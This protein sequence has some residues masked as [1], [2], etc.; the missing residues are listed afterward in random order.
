MK[1]FELILYAPNT[2]IPCKWKTANANS[3]EEFEE[4]CDNDTYTNVLLSSGWRIATIRE[5]KIGGRDR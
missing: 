4:M 5:V 2:Y 1:T 3:I